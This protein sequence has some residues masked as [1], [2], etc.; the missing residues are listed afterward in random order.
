MNC[1]YRLFIEHPYSIGENY[2]TH[3]YQAIN[4]SYKF[5][6]FSINELIHALV[7]GIDIFELCNTNSTIE[8]EKILDNL[9]NRN[10]KN[11]K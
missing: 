3:F 10:L 4:F 5:F 11:K 8:L 2:F 9:K 6:S 1:F 7:P